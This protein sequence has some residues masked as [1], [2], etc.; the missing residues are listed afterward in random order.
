MQPE[1][2]VSLAHMGQTGVDEFSGITFSYPNEGIAQIYTASQLQT[3]HEALIV[4]DK[5]MIRIP[6]RFYAADSGKFTLQMKG[7]APQEFDFP[8]EDSGYRYEAEEVVRCMREGLMESPVLPLSE[9][10]AIMQT[11]DRIQAAWGTARTDTTHGWN[12]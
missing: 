9:T 5:G 3:P 7:E 11:M 1:K 10:L 12:T 8:V 6:G 2:V 4:G